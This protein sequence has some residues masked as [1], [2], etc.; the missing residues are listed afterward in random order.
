MESA[1]CD[2]R[3]ATVGSLLFGSPD[4]KIGALIELKCLLTLV[5]AVTELGGCQSFQSHTVKG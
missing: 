1:K 4:L 3:L 2:L 5:T